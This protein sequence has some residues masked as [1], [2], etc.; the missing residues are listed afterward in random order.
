M[1]VDKFRR[2]FEC[3][4][5]KDFYFVSCF[6]RPLLLNYALSVMSLYALSLSLSQFSG[7]ISF[8]LEKNIVLYDIRVN[9]VGR[10]R[11]EKSKLFAKICWIWV[12]PFRLGLIGI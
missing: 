1:F 10:V 2:V 5:P 6:I 12:D 3:S 7:F 9:P 8:D 11:I 4:S